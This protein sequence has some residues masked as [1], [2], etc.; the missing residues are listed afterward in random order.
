MYIFD[1]VYSC[2]TP[3]VFQL[4]I[5]SSPPKSISWH[6]E[7]RRCIWLARKKESESL[8]EKGRENKPATPDHGCSSP[9]AAPK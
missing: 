2:I 1:Y 7:S 3:Q 5:P 9:R 8:R 4:P 6:L